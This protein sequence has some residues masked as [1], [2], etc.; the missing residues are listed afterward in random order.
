MPALP[1][2]A[3]VLRFTIEG[4]TPI[5]DWANVLHWNYTGGVPTT[6]DCQNLSDQLFGAWSTNFAALMVTGSHVLKS[7]C[8]DLSSDLGSSGETVGSVVGTRGA[9]EIPGSAC[10][11]I[12]KTIARRYRGGHPRTY[13]FAGVQGDLLD[14][15]HW[16]APFLTAVE[17][18]Y[19]AVRAAMDAAVSGATT[20]GVEVIVSYIDSTVTPAP[21]HRR[22]VPL[23]F[24]VGA[25]V[26]EAT[27]ATQRRRIGR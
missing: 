27:I 16:N 24:P 8:V 4:D 22:I 12:R 6:V 7:T 26:T 10:C 20:L 15:S 25:F 14:E 5:H 9:V 13:A 2:V 18:G 1:A 11:L 19:T 3:N 23:V 21:P 17:V